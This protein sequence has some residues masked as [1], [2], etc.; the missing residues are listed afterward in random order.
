M[1]GISWGTC[2]DAYNEKANP[3]DLIFLEYANIIVGRI[4]SKNK[5]DNESIMPAN[6][7]NVIIYSPIS[8]ISLDIKW[9]LRV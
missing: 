8:N 7:N 3:I 4:G 6:L 5:I 1:K 2:S 9:R